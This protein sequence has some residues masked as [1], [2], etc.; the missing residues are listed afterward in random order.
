MNTAV[1]EKPAEP[2]QQEEFAN[3][4]TFLNLTGDI[5]I[6]W[7]EQNDAK[8]KEM[9]RSKMKQGYTFFTL[10]KVV[11]DSVR[12]KRKIGEKGIDSI[13]SLVIDD[14]DF[15]K[16][17]ARVDDKD[18]AGLLKSSD[19]RLVKRRGNTRELTLSSRLKDADEVVKAKQAVAIRPV[20]GG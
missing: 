5:T 1:L 10:R 13:T 18:V 2:Q 16:L 6:S 12:V 3:A 7:D 11:V 20:V 15:D 4:I 17:V 9:V 8:I 14:A 19:A